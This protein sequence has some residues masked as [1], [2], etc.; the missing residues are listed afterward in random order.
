MTEEYET[1]RVRKQMVIPGDAAHCTECSGEVDWLTVS[2]VSAAMQIK[3]E[4]L[5]EILSGDRLHFK[6]KRGRVL[7]IC[8]NAVSEF[9]D[10]RT[11]PG[12]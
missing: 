6:V 3:P 12:K 5:L 2:E 4:E 1:I 8:G 7:L 11:F 10:R 9:G